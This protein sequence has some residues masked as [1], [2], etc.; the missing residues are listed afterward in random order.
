M[1]LT[2]HTRFLGYASVDTRA[3]SPRCYQ[4]VNQ[5]L[6]Y[7]CDDFSVDIRNSGQVPI[8]RVPG[9]RCGVGMGVG[10]RW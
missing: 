3:E 9:S 6:A 10:D 2:A 5:S 7:R 8:G 4:T 1:P